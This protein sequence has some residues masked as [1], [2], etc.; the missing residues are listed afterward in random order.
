M[1]E[2]NIRNIYTGERRRLDGKEYE[3]S[4]TN[5]LSLTL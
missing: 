2:M 3:R 1:R 5:K 4:K